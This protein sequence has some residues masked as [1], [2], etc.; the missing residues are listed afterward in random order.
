MKPA[1]A[2]AFLWLTSAGAANWSSCPGR[3][4]GAAC[5]LSSGA[6]AAGVGSSGAGLLRCRLRN[7]QDPAS[8]P[9]P[10]QFPG[11][12]GKAQLGACASAVQRE[13]GAG[14]ASAQSIGGAAFQSCCRWS[15]QALR[16]WRPGRTTQELSEAQ[17]SAALARAPPWCVAQAAAAS[18]PPPRGPCRLCFAC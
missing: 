15:A 4:G 6:A 9:V 3:A 10:T 1:V 5:G 12:L 14:A 11:E 16:G 13:A 8:D 2:G 18:A 17:Q 7:S